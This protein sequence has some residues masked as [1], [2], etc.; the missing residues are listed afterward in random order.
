[1]ARNI[2]PGPAKMAIS[3]VEDSIWGITASPEFPMVQRLMT[4]F[5]I[6]ESDEER[7]LA[8]YK[9]V[10]E[11][12]D[13]PLIRFLL[14]LIIVDEERHHEAM[15]SMITGLKDDLATTGSG[16][17][18]PWRSMPGARIKALIQTLER[19]REIERQGIKAYKRLIKL[20]EAFQ[21][22]LFALVCRTMIHD[23][24]KHIG[25]LDFLSAKLR[26][27]TPPHVGRH[28]YKRK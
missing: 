9:N 7:W 15:G 26:G 11:R 4:A 24:R 1:M 27:T 16:K 5:K 25:I 23:S 6:H 17:P 3:S 8:I 12:S 13:D 19:F 14:H 10:A 21:Q 22:D 2:T 18:V 20:S 28:K